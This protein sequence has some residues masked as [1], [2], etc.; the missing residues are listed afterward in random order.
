[1][2]ALAVAVFLLMPAIG[3]LFSLRIW[4]FLR[5]GLRVTA[6]IVGYKEDRWEGGID[7]D[8]SRSLPIVSF[9]DEHGRAHRVT[10]SQERP[11]QWKGLP[12]DEIKL[13]Y[14][15]GDPQHPKIAHWSLLWMVPMFLFAP[16][17]ILLIALGWLI[18]S[19]KLPG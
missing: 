14:R 7:T 17:I 2:K 12:D 6:R 9:R 11:I 16:A 3:L 8:N 18:L 13:I 15:P 4:L 1:M 19:A 10:L 5:T